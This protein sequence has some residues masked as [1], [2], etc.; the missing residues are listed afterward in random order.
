MSGTKILSGEGKM[1]VMVVGEHSCI[2]KIRVLLEKDD[3][4]PTPLQ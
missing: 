3:P 2:G 4:E 1:V